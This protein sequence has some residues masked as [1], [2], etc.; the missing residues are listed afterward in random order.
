MKLVDLHVHSNSSDGIF[1]PAELIKRAAEA[2]VSLIALADHDSIDG[3][4]EAMRVATTADI[5][6]IPAVELSVEYD[7]YSDVHILGYF[8]NHNDSHFN[9]KLLHFRRRRETRGLQV[10][11]R[12]NEKLQSEG[13]K[14]IDSDEIMALA[15][16]SLGRP[17]IARVL[18]E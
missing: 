15:E 3:L 11:A 2:G 13:K 18:I 7:R 4:D 10:I 17:H 16:G 9:E 5:T 6:V 8:I 12:I 14:P 1:A